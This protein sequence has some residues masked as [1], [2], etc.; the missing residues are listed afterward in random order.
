[1]VILYANSKCGFFGGVEQNVADSAA[2]L[3]QRGH[4]CHLAF[5]EDS[6]NGTAAFA[7]LFRGVHHLPEPPASAAG[8]DRAA[9]A[10]LLEH[11]QPDAVFLHRVPTLRPWQDQP[12]ACR[13]VRMIHDHD[14]C[15]PRRHKYFLS[16]G[17]VCQHRAD[18]RCWFDG[19]FVQRVRGARLGF[20]LVNL[21]AHAAERRRHRRLDLVLAGSR[22]MAEELRQNRVPADKIRILH[23][24]VNAPLCD[25]PAPLPDGTARVL[26]VGQ[27]IRGK[28]VDLLLRALAQVRTPHDAVIV[29]TGN[30]EAGLRALCHDLGLDGRVRFAGWIANSELPAHYQAATVLAVPSRW[31][32]PFGMVGLEAM[33]RARPV[34]AFAV[35]GIP[36]WLAHEKT[37]LLV[38]EQDVAGFAAA[39]DRVL[40]DRAGAARLGREG[41]ARA[42]AEFS[43]TRYLDC[44]EAHLRGAAAPVG[45][46]RTEGARP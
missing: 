34:V 4:A 38:P 39:L 37:G 23:P 21:V 31:P 28:G 45:P 27:L 32:E 6:G 11:L 20:A 42:R 33:H 43:F 14:V 41:Q 15:C 2:G 7:G 44:L 35:G 29:G 16:N 12:R 13:T 9:V 18:W 1:V 19:A 40:A 25:D 3:A 30:A 36:D 46:A 26:F 24:V 8:P 17:R 5:G 10:A 22:F